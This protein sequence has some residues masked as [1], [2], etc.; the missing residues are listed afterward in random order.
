LNKVAVVEITT[1][2][3]GIIQEVPLGKSEGLSRSCVANCDNLRTVAVSA[4]VKR[5]GALPAVKQT[6]LK[7]AIGHSLGWPELIAAE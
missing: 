6:M 5:A 4:L 7:R 3:R 2:V 1:S